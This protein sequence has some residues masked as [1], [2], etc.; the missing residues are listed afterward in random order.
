MQRERPTLV[1]NEIVNLKKKEKLINQD[2]FKV[3]RLIA[4]IKDNHAEF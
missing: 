2:V 3:K 1:K 4:Q